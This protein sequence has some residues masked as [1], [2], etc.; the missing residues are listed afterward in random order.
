VPLDISAFRALDRR[1]YLDD[2]LIAAR[3]RDEATRS[4]LLNCNEP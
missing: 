4:T 1:A 2:I 3:S